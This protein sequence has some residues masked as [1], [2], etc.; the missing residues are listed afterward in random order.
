ML[1]PLLMNVAKS[2]VLTQELICSIV[3]MHTK[4]S[5][6]NQ[7]LLMI[8]ELEMWSEVFPSLGLIGV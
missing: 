4:H 3:H 5:N 1:H 8:A 7:S 6:Q 2:L